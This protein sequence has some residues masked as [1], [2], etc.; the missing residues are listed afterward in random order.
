MYPFMFLY[1]CLLCVCHVCVATSRTP[2]SWSLP[3][4]VAG[5]V[6]TFFLLSFFPSVLRPFLFALKKKRAT[7][8]RQTAGNS[9]RGPRSQLFSSVLILSLEGLPETFFGVSRIFLFGLQFP[10]EKIHCSVT[11]PR[12]GA[13]FGA[14]CAKLPGNV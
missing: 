5:T 9:F 12:P 11:P 6:S 4:A 14:I 10:D 2:P 7:E 8:V 3:S 13:V 1:M